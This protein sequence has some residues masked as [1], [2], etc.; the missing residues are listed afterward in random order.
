MRS[1]AELQKMFKHHEDGTVTRLTYEG[2]T[3][4]IGDTVGCLSNGYLKVRMDDKLYLLHKVLF[5]MHHGYTPHCVD[6]ADN[7]P[8]NNRIDNL[9]EATLSQNSWNTRKQS[10]KCS[11]I[12]KGVNQIKATSKWRAYIC[13]N[14]KQKHLGCFDTEE[15]AAQ[16]YDIALLSIEPEFGMFNFPKENYNR[17]T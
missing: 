3:A 17:K 14:Y 15:E 6:H 7:N 1:Q 13:I 8:L 16:A 12:Y 9:R 5:Q 11:S 4:K 2:S 10:K